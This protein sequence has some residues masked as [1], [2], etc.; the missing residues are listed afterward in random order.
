MKKQKPARIKDSCGF[1]AWQGQ[2]DTPVS[3]AASSATVALQQYPPQTSELKTVHRTVFFTLLTPLGFKSFSFCTFPKQKT[4][5]LGGF[6]FMAG[7]E[8]LE[9]SARGF[10]A[11]PEKHTK[12]SC[13]NKRG[14]SSHEVADDS[15]TNCQNKLS[16]ASINSTEP[17]H[18]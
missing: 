2:K 13:F 12:L 10:G 1:F 16:K 3:Q 11:K 4:T 17:E 9:P 18:M 7:A 15:T 14:A 5:L 8:G 6:L